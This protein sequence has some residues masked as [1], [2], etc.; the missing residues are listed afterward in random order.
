LNHNENE[1]DK[2]WYSFLRIAVG[3]SSCAS[4][5]PS[6]CTKLARTS[7]LLQIK[8]STAHHQYPVCCSTAL[9][10]YYRLDWDEGSE[11][12]RKCKMSV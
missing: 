8:P 11:M 10:T 1:E 5:P 7:R 2:P 4:R 6:P 9:L 12:G 3:A